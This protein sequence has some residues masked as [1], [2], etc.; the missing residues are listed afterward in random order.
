MDLPHV[1]SVRRQL[2]ELAGMAHQVEAAE[3]RILQRA[4]GLLAD[5]ERK[6]SFAQAKAVSEPQAYM[7]LIRERGRLLQV[8]A[9]ARAVLAL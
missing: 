3:R 5:V 4:E 1:E 2:G 6:L 7:D 9:Q 8:I